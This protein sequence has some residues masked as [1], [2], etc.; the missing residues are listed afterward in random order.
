[1]E[2][3]TLPHLTPQIPTKKGLSPRRPNDGP[4]WALQ[5]TTK[6]E[7]GH[8]CPPKDK[9]QTTKTQKHEKKVKSE[10]EK[11][12]VPRFAELRLCGKKEIDVLLFTS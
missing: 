1:L 8:S 7:G 10:K 5:I 9:K 3:H 4:S 11:P 6:Q 2:F 12:C